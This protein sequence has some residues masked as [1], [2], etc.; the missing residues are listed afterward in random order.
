[1]LRI[2]RLFARRR[3][4]VYALCCAVVALSVVLVIS[5]HASA[6]PSSLP[7]GQ[8]QTVAAEAKILVDT[9]GLIEITASDLMSSDL[10]WQSIDPS[11]VR[12]FFQGRPQ[13]VWIE[14]QGA[15]LTLKF[16]GQ[17]AQS[18]YTRDNAYFL[19]IDHQ[20]VPPL[21]MLTQTLAARSS[22]AI[23][24]YTATLHAEENHLY[25]PLVPDGDH[26]FWAQLPAPQTKTF[27]VELSAV[28]D[29]PAQIAIGVWGSTEAPISPDHHLRVKINGQNVADRTW[30]GIA[31]HT[32][33]ADVPPGLLVAGSNL[34]QIEAP[35][36]TGAAADIT[37]IDWIEIRYL[38]HFVAENDRLEFDGVDGTVQLSGFSGPIDLFD[39]TDPDRP[40]RLIGPSTPA[41]GAIEI[42]VQA[43]RHYLAVGPQGYPSAASI[44]PAATSPDLKAADNGADYIAIGPADLLASLQPL[45]NWHQTQKLKVLAVPAETIYDQFGN[46]LPEPEAIHAFLQYASQH[47][48]TPP[49]FVLLVGDA[50]YDPLGYSGLPDGNRLP[51]FLVQTIY[52]G[53]TASDVGFVQLNDDPLPDLPIGRVP[54]RTADQVTTWVNKTLAYEQSAPSGDW[55]Q[56]ILAVADGQESSFQDE[57][58]S[59]LKR[60]PTRYQSTLVNPA[61]GL[62][63]A[64]QNVVAD[65]NQGDLLVAYFGHGSVTQWGK[66][67]LFT[68]GDVAALNNGDHL[69]V[70]LNLT[71]L[72]GLFTHPKVE[73]L[74]ETLLWKQN[75]GAV[76]VL[77]PTSLT[78]ATNQSLL[79][80]AFVDAFVADPT[81]PLGQIVLKA[82]R[83]VPITDPSTQDVLRTFTLFGDPALRLVQP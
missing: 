74:A 69:P 31:R 32:L 71:C 8:S 41:Q 52:G 54:A 79:S 62:S 40:V 75:G 48:T 16:F 53:E 25:S 56:R 44:V 68:T 66:D 77:A 10:G 3:L 30:D 57:A 37:F 15:A 4:V 55:R 29:G 61:A 20:L 26:W 21:P 18:R 82:W 50:T 73:S 34:I 59:F 27:T 42:G 80:N 65:I 7:T 72:T 46:G 60:F 14:G 13:P 45:L 36:D 81:A 43:D 12:L 58:A 24:H 23:D 70:V 49:K 2:S 17:A 67:N 19:Q 47:W 78:L 64:N 83:A 33:A 51:T 76:A 1:M 11:N 28:A 63:N 5:S 38:R 9:A 6:P 22:V 39:I 35:G